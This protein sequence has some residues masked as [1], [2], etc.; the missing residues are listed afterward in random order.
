MDH[1]EIYKL[2][3]LIEILIPPVIFKNIVKFVMANPT[4]INIKILRRLI[5]TN[6]NYTME[7]YPRGFSYDGGFGRLFR[8]F[9]VEELLFIFPEIINIPNGIPKYSLFYNLNKFVSSNG[10]GDGDKVV[11]KAKILLNIYENDPNLISDAIPGHGRPIYDFG[12]NKKR[13]SRCKTKKSLHKK[14][15]KKLKFY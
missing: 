14:M 8:D 6:R 4:E 11:E 7:D 3:Q 2:Y 10:E 15:Q 5:N 9:N 13:K 1:S 12:K